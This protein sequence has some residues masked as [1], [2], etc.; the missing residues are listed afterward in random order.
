MTNA[1]HYGHVDTADTLNQFQTRTTGW[2]GIPPL[3]P[4][5]W[6]RGSARCESRD[7]ARPAPAW[8]TIVLGALLLTPLGFFAFIVLPVWLIVVGVLL[9]RSP[10]TVSPATHELTPQAAIEV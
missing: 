1:A 3:R 2:P 9:S 5:S 6:P 10:A 8:V 7:V 4:F